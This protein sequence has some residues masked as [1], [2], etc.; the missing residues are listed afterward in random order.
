MKKILFIIVLLISVNGVSA[1]E[2]WYMSFNAQ[3]NASYIMNQNSYGAPE[4]NY[5]TTIGGGGNIA[6]GVNFNP[7][8]GLQLNGG[9]T[10]GGQ[11]YKDEFKLGPKQFERNERDIDLT[12]LTVGLL[13]RYSPILPRQQYID[14]PKIKMVIAVGPQIDWL[15]KADVVYKRAMDEVGYPFPQPDLGYKAVGYDKDLYQKLV[16]S[17]VL[18]I[19][20]DYL[21]SEKFFIN[22]ALRTEVGFNDINAKAYRKHEGYGASRIFNPG[23][24][25]GLGFYFNRN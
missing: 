23:I 6:A 24:Q 4:L 7:E 5:E 21:V 1:Q 19:G 17:G 9:I 25:F 12:Y 10:K 8:L 18:S 20:I 3:A 11:K 2:G 22:A 13:F 15:A 16:I 14:D